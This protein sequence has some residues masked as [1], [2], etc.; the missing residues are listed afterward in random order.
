ML[1][2]LPRRGFV[3]SVACLALTPVAF[4]QGASSDTVVVFAAASLKTAL[5]AAGKQWTAATGK[6]IV[7]S[8]AASGA[9]AKQIENGAPADL[10]AS[11]DL[12]WMD[13]AAEKKLIVPESRTPLLGNTLVLI[14]PK[15]QASDLKIAKGFKL[16]EALGDSRLA[17][18]DPKSVP[19]GMYTQTALTSLGVWEA[20]GPKIAGAD[21]VR[22][23]LA[24]VA[25]GEARFGI[26]YRTDAISE[27]K[28]R[29]V[30]TF[31]SDSHPPI[32]YPFALTTTS[33]NPAAADF[34]AF[35][36]TPAAAKV[37]ETEGFAVLP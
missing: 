33:K 3:A 37:F 30:D 11:A 8:Y 27:P 26:V 1:P 4:G 35:L 6:K 12:K 17:T 22:G 36:K 9:L 25:R 29:V 5:D 34:L 31:P 32:I 10:F 16:A 15:D 2:D 14:A 7:F 19:A 28:V 24:F 13:Y 18:G 23:A 20:V 21:N